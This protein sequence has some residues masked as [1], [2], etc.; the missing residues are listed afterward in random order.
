M[1]VFLLL[2]SR[3]LKTVFVSTRSGLKM[4][5]CYGNAAHCHAA[6]RYIM[7]STTPGLMRVECGETCRVVPTP[8]TL[9]ALRH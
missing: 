3:H 7:F 4:T 8:G 2:V 1:E 9:Q 6:V 5:A